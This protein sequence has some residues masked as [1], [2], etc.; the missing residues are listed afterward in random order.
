MKKFIFALV[1]IVLFSSVAD[2]AVRA[3]NARL[4]RNRGVVAVNVNN[5]FRLF[6][7][8]GFV[9]VNAFNP[10]FGFVNPGFAGYGFANPGIAAGCGGVGFANPGF[11]FVSTNAFVRAAVNPFFASPFV[12]VRV[13]RGFGFSLFR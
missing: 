12:D 10:G 1:A 6:A 4:F 3:R 2:A 13:G 11:G 8:R 9:G 7:N 5:G